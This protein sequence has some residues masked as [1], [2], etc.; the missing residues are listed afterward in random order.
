[1]KRL[2]LPLF[3]VLIAMMTT[4]SGGSQAAEPAGRDYY[5]D[6]ALG[7]DT[8]DG[9]SAKVNGASGPVKTIARAIKLAAPGDTVH[10]MPTTYRESA[11]FHNR[12]G[13]PGR[14][15]TLDGHG[16]ILE[17]SD[18]IDPATWEQV[19]P[20]LYRNDKLIRADLL[21]RDDALIGRWFFLFDGKMNHMGRTSKGKSEPLKKPE[22][23]QPGEWTIVKAEHAFYIRIDPAK[24]LG[25][26]KISAPVRGNGVAIGGDCS[27][28]VVRNVT[29]THVYND[30]YNI[31]G[32]TRDVVFEN[33]AAIECGDDGFSAH[34]DCT[35]R[36]DGFISIGNST[37]ITNTGRSQSENCRVW[38][39]D[40]LGFDFF[41][42]DEGYKPGEDIPR[43][44]SQTLIDSV[45]LS[46]AGRC[47]AV[48]GSRGLD[49]P[50]RM[51]LENV[52]VRRVGRP[53]EARVA[54]HSE[55]IADHVTMIDVTLQATG[56]KVELR[57]SV[58]CG[59]S[60]PKIILWADTT[61][62]ADHNRY[63]L[64]A[65]QVDKAIY[66]PAMFA[67]Y[68][69]ATGQDAHSI[70]KPVT[71]E[72]SEPRDVDSGVGVDRSRLPKR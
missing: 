23:L 12:H 68:Q 45:I 46:S 38:I 29:G 6:P 60:S 69:Q 5:V 52:L 56:G 58:L 72:N 13:E 47:I 28:L 32:K 33:I 59:S 2:V 19:A 15:I 65:I 9:R 36:V 48:D 37:G 61:W 67:A 26:Y 22:D 51:K 54:K 30:G 1:M 34:D 31:H 71:I 64:K 20:G 25:D 17:G 63:D 66:A 8:S 49:E 57:N 40:C 10:L 53:D 4:W 62:K 70:L 18:P 44:N 16:A 55:L 42:L 39:Q 43:C 11:A 21:T 27:H 14:P 50:C 7:N 3:L 41:A 24:S 35:V